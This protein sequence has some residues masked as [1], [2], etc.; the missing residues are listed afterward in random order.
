MRKKWSA[1]KTI[2]GT[3]EQQDGIFLSLIQED[4]S[5]L[6]ANSTMLRQLHLKPAGVKSLNFFDLIDPVN[7]PDFK[8]AVQRSGKEKEVCSME[9]FLKNGYYHPMKW[10]INHLKEDKERNTYL[11]VG[12]KLLDDDRLQQFNQLG[13]KNYQ[14]IVEGLNAGILFQDTQGE[15]ISANQKTAEIFNTTLERLYQLTE[16]KNLWNAAWEI[17]TEEGC[18]VLFQDTP[19]MRAL[20]TGTT[21]T[22]VLVVKLRNGEQRWLQFSSQPLFNDTSGEAY[23][24]ISNIAD[25]THEKQ[26]ILELQQRKALFGSFMDQTPSLTWV[27]DEDSTLVFASKAFY[28]Y[29]G[30]DKEKSR[31]SKITDLVPA[32]VA[33]LFYEKHQEVFQTGKSVEMVEKVNWADGT[34]YVFHI[35]IFLIDDVPGK[36]MLGGHAV[37]LA[38]KFAAEKKLKET[39]DRLLLI[40]RATTDAI[41]EWDMQT[42]YIFRNDALMDM[43]GYQIGD[44]K[45]LSWWLRRIHPEDR[46]RVGDKVKEA[47]EHNRQSWEDEYRFKCADGEYKHMRDKG[48]IVYENGLP[49]KMIG[50]LQDVSNLKEMENHLMEE[51]LE[52]QKEISEAIIRAQEK[53]R[54]KIGH[55][56]HDNVNQILSTTRL[57]VEMLT[58]ISKAEAEIKGKSLEYILLVIEEIR[59]LSKELVVPQLKEKGLIDS[60]KVL[61]DD[62]HLSSTVRIKFTHDHENDLLAPG[63]KVTLFRIVQEQLKN[64]LKHSKA[65]KVNIYLQQKDGNTQLIIS[66][67]G[68]GFDARKTHQGIGLSNI[69]ERA[70]FYNGSADIESVPGE[71]CTLTVLIPSF[72]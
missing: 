26:L 33:K 4:G 41:W 7:M 56:L 45:G 16:I 1:L 71:G 55:E 36:K 30:I 52:S 60:I 3:Y 70:R 8:N 53:E 44:Q 64:I 11:C 54:T 34:N 65:C 32:P 27:V 51:K 35:N 62:I 25:L 59:K 38:D 40:T 23:S 69:Y 21:Q 24:V 39:N 48:Y 50:S 31:N 42:G 10:E 67:N 15:I 47:T 28:N 13:E 49:V 63:K 12:H 2:I 43:I 29:F 68:V 66:D 18:R 14:L 72:Q 37:N 58:P 22:Q 61:I 20:Q 57:F 19:F 5:I 17:T 9:I 46:D 6:C